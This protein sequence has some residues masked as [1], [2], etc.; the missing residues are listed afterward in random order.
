MI[1]VLCG[2]TCSGKTYLK[3]KLSKTLNIKNVVT[4][5]TRKPRE[6]EVDG[7]DYHFVDLKYLSSLD[8]N[9][10]ILEADIIDEELY[11]IS[12]DSF[13]K[14]EEDYVIVLSYNGFKKLKL[15]YPN[16]VVGI[17]LYREEDARR[18]SFIKRGLSVSDFYKR[19]YSILPQILKAEDDKNIY[20]VDN[21]DCYTAFYDLLEII[22]MELKMRGIENKMLLKENKHRGRIISTCEYCNEPIYED[23]YMTTLL[24][25]DFH[26]DMNC[27]EN[28]IKE[29]VK[30][31]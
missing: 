19:E 22:E 20:H 15:L 9:G 25:M 14:E 2:N 29:N 16:E 8:K 12:K 27:L 24:D 30:R 7:V 3:N 6:G 26:D 13:V 17:L 23:N 31:G 11:A 1:I 21:N 28:W 5:T 4:Y 18:E 10:M